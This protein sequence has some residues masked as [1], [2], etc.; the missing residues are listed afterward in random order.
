VIHDVDETLRA[1][2][3]RTA[4]FG[5]DVEVVFDAPTKEWSSRRNAPSI[6]MYLYDLREDLRRRHSGIQDVHENGR[7]TTRVQP[8][9]W[10]KL[11]YLVTAWTQRPEDE[12]RL[13]SALLRSLLLADRL[14]PDLLAGSLAGLQESVPYTCALPPP[15]DRALS[16]VWSA[17]GGE[18][19]PSIDLVVYAPFDLSRE[20]TIGPPVT[21]GPRFDI[22][23][24]GVREQRVGRVP[25]DP[26]DADDADRGDDADADDDDDV[27]EADRDGAAARNDDGR[28]PA[29]ERDRAP[30]TSGG[31]N[32]AGAAQ[33]NLGMRVRH[34]RERE[35]GGPRR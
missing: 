1:M 23:G 22:S 27:D 16:D 10:F 6:D 7:V 34:P 28:S 4:L 11:S 33:A 5:T 26:A 12:H 35:Q 3:R 14:P 24:P 8:P 25:P 20:I 29:G 13:L 30:T 19:K 31:P 17:L 15:E 2:V 21:E 32:R 18:L 9:R